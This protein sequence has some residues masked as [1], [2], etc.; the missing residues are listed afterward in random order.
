MPTLVSFHAHPDDE[1]I[2][3]GGTLAKAV[4]DG[5][6][7]V[8]VYA[9]RGELGESPDGLLAPGEPLVER[10]HREVMRSTAALGVHRVEFLGYRDSGMMGTPDNE[11]PGSFWQADL[12]EATQR[13]AAILRDEAADVLLTYDENGNYGHPDHLQVHRVGVRAAALAGTPQVLEATINR[14][15]I[16]NFIERAVAAGDMTWDDVPDLDDPDQ[17]F[18]MPDELITTRVDVRP[19]AERKL[20]AMRAHETQ[21]G[22]LAPFLAMP[23]PEF[24]ESMGTEYFIRRGVSPGHR[25][26]DVFAGLEVA[27]R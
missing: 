8:V 2:T 23:F 15:S 13:L 19:W 5:H 9:T 4:D 10:R 26:D 20:A 1:C 14:D 18:G 21:V 16:R 24:R 17:V 11:H 25:D 3:T 22:D 7:V 12:D 6:R 27:D